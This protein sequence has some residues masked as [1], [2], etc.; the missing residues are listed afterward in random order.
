MYFSLSS[1]QLESKTVV[2]FFAKINDSWKQ[3][4]QVKLS[5]VVWSLLLLTFNVD[6]YSISFMKDEYSLQSC[7]QTNLNLL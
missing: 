5:N 1:M 2:A 6:K 3:S 7:E 4:E